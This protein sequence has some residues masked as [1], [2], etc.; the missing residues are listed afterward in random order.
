MMHGFSILDYIMNRFKS[1]LLKNIIVTALLLTQLSITGCV[2]LSGTRSES[3]GKKQNIQGELHTMRGGLGIFSIGMNQLQNA[4]AQKYPIYTS[5]TM[6]Y[7]AG[8]LGRSIISHHEKYHSTH[9]IILIGHSLGGDDQIR[10]ARSL[11]KAGIPVALLVTVDA[12]SPLKV[13]PNVAYALNIY[14]PG[15]VPMFSGWRL[16]AQDPAVT[17]VENINVN[18]LKH[19]EVNHF[20]IDKDKT[21]QAIIL[22]H[23]EK[24]LAHANRKQA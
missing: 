7:K 11:N 17:R 3:M 13:P 10:V 5:N 20:T 8:R 4:A 15:F 2:D 19:V 12:V 23:V 9:P 16:I 18:T 21:V 14:K 1:Q 22:Q 24:V 6:W